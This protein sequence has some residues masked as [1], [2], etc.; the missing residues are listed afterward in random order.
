MSQHREPQSVMG[1]CCNRNDENATAD[2]SPAAQDDSAE[3]WAEEFSGQSV[4]GRCRTRK[5]ENGGAE[6]V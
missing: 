1:R 5:D 2:P 6:G 3:E 4:M